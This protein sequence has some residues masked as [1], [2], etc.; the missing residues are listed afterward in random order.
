VGWW[1]GLASVAPS[2]SHPVRF[3]VPG[4]I[5]TTKS[6]FA[7]RYAKILSFPID[8]G[9]ADPGA[10]DDRQPAPDAHNHNTT[11]NIRPATSSRP[12]PAHRYH[13]LPA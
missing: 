4:F 2:S 3:L 7:P 8:S 9:D 12:D 1:A 5:S 10:G 11:N 6:H 13:S